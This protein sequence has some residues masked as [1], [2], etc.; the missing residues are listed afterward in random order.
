MRV[1]KLFL[2]IFGTYF[3]Y[4]Y[5]YF[6]LGEG[7]VLS[8]SIWYSAFFLWDWYLRANHNTQFFNMNKT[9]IYLYLLPF[10]TVVLYLLTLQT[11]ASYDVVG[12]F[13][14]ILM[15]LLFGITWIYLSLRGMFLFWSFSYQ[16][17]VLMGR[18]I[19]ALVA[20][21]G[22]F[23]G[24]SFI[25]AGANIGDGPGWWTIVWA[26]GLG[27][28][29]WLVLGGAVK[30]CTCIVDTVLMDRDIGSGIRLGCFWLAC[31]LILA[32][33]SAGDWTSF[34][35]TVAEFTSGWPAIPLTVIMIVMERLMF[36]EREVWEKEDEGN[37]K[38]ILA[39]AFYI[40]YAVVTVVLLP[41]VF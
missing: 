17:D 14:Y 11:V 3:C 40:I 5:L 8:F 33:A 10:T 25:Y 13:L 15:Y 4:E 18:N 34:S 26:G 20:F 31:G 9:R 37:Q 2:L 35:V 28:A 24:V 7:V 21:S 6:S 38:T 22:A 29:A 32:R 23:L 27:T 16:D 12:D 39:S 36:R 41:P 30:R 1:G 19:A